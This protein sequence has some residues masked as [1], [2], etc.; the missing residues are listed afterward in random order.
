MAAKSFED[1][2]KEIRRLNQ[3]LQNLG[4]GGMK[5]KDLE[6]ALKGFNGDAQAA[7]DFLAMMNEQANEMHYTFTGIHETLKNSLQDL[8]GQVE[9]TNQINK[10]YSKLS[11]VANQLSN[12]QKNDHVLSV[13][14]LKNIQ[15]EV[16]I[17]IKKLENAR[18]ELAHKKK[19]GL[20]S[21]KEQEYYREVNKALNLKNSYLKQT[22]KELDKE[23]KLEQKRADNLGLTQGMFKGIHGLME[24]IGVESEAFDNINKA[25]REAAGKGGV[26][27][28]IGAGIKA[29]VS[30][31]KD[32]FFNI[33]TSIGI[34]TK[35][36]GF[37][38]DAAFNY[39][40]QAFNLQQSLGLSWKDASKLNDELN[41]AFS[42]TGNLYS[43]HQDLVKSQIAL[44]SAMGT[45]NAYST[46]AL[47]NF[48][49]L[50]EVAGM[51]TEEAAKLQEYGDLY[52]QSSEEIYD[53]IGKTKKGLFSSKHV[54]SQVLKING[55]L[56]AQYKNNPKLLAQAVVQANKIGLSLE[57]AKDAASG[58]LD[59]E[60]S[61]Q[62]EMEAE[63]LTG[64]NLNLEQARYLA[65]QGDSAGAAELMLK[66]VG[67]IDEF[68][69]MNVIS[70][71]AIAKSM[72]MNADTMAN[73]LV[74]EKQY[75]N[76][77]E[78][79]KKDLQERVKQL[80]A[81][82]KYEEAAA[83]EKQVLNDE[84]GKSVKLAEQELSARKKSEKAME[85]LKQQFMSSIAPVAEK[86]FNMLT[87][88]M[89]FISKNP[90]IK[91]IIKVV[92]G[93]LAIGAVVASMASI[94]NIVKKAFSGGGIMGIFAKRGSHP[95]A[96]L[97]TS[98]IGGM[99]MP[100]GPM[101]PMG[102]GSTPGGSKKNPKNKRGKPKPKKSPPRNRFRGPNLMNLALGAAV[103]YGGYQ[104]LFGGEDGGGEEAMMAGMIGME[105]L[106]M[107]HTMQSVRQQM[108]QKT[109]SPKPPKTPKAPK[110]N[111][112][113]K[114]IDKVKTAYN[115]M[116][117]GA[118]KAFDSAK[119]ATLESKIASKAKDMTAVISKTFTGMKTAITSSKIAQVTTKFVEGT[120]KVVSN[121]V[122]AVKTGFNATKTA[123]KTVT[124]TA[125]ATV[126]STKIGSAIV[127]NTQTAGKTIQ[128]F[129]KVTGNV[130]S[131]G[132]PILDLALGGYTGYSEVAG[133]TEDD[134][135]AIGV[136]RDMG[137]TEA[138]FQG[139]F[140]GSA[141]RGSML[142]DM[143][144]YFGDEDDDPIIE[145]GGAVDESLG[146]LGAAG[147]GAMT[148]AAIGSM[149]P[150]P[151]VGT[152]IGAAVGGVVG[153]VG[154]S[155]K[156]LM[157]ENSNLRKGLNEAWETTK[158]WSANTWEATKEWT[159]N[160][161]ETTKE[162]AA[163][164]KDTVVSWAEDTGNAF[165]SWGESASSFFGDMGSGITGFF[166]DVGGGMS[167]WLSD[168]GSGVSDFASNTL[169][170]IKSFGSGVVDSVSSGISSAYDSVSSGVS[171]FM[172]S[173]GLAEGGII[174]SPTKALI[175]EG[176]KKEAIV[177][178]DE[179]YAKIDQLINAVNNS[180]G[181]GGGGDV[182][183][184]GQKVGQVI[185]M[186]ARGIQ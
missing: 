183:L 136:R 137:E 22:V 169:D 64:K 163:N 175:G 12:H 180:Q 65:L 9:A 109:Q 177:P 165:I 83:L 110:N 181:G 86:F 159:A 147:R 55:Q 121:G 81:A 185:S 18:K 129:T 166:G 112:I 29:T 148:G 3:S 105:G 91:D 138:I 16:E 132:L 71:E 54:M 73:A 96:P 10:S 119:T 19:I 144:N 122:N 14:K 101:G 161:W 30:E 130:L 23:V 127:K 58:L 37:F 85:R 186:N 128:A 28:T 39:S 72:G 124:E 179:F 150:I 125:K 162:W 4:K 117:D 114:G 80:K 53:T 36:W 42:T 45:T 15:K 120:V 56:S 115:K 82:G 113:N 44:N 41:Y 100:G 70:Q 174:S 182:Y 25:M 43:T 8:K 176:G 157:D 51:T 27:K 142:S 108:P 74:K 24:K 20:L 151:G 49:K 93:G 133:M 103:T 111:F 13:K 149:I 48:T 79:R 5:T 66:Q 140:T 60:S 170:G 156:L 123:V 118:V 160:T 63:L 89:D 59:F 184:D 78:K 32:S 153:A 158:E 50:T 62:N 104:M 88:V 76:L 178:L 171:S 131:K 69:K 141:S 47:D 84:S 77:G 152:A 34:L 52:G 145:K 167:D 116:A 31:M 87:S 126:E 99:G 143:V 26:F 67:G 168:L 164:T 155:V 57:Q 35:T 68:N 38:K 107:H 106:Q 172:S 135:E 146:V 21:K 173:I 102:P 40:D 154:E 11:S 75:Q 17:E 6:N 98:D 94:G 95:G 92:G 2:E 33:S 139:L 61:I 134:K 7:R 1:L 46:S 90:I 97:F